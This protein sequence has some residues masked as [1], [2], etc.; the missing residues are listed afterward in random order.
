MLAE[1]K[2]TNCNN[3]HVHFVHLNNFVRFVNKNVQTKR[4]YAKNIF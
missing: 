2:A 4:K 1:Q 3:Q